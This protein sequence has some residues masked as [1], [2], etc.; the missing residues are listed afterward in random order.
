ME[1]A[2]EHYIEELADEIFSKTSPYTIDSYGNFILKT[3][4]VVVAMSYQAFKK[5]VIDKHQ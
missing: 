1:Q 5:C 4:K 2:F 3:D